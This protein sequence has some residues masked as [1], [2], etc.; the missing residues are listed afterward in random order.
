MTVRP[1]ADANTG[2]RQL[3]SGVQDLGCETIPTIRP[4]GKVKVSSCS[5]RCGCYRNPLFVACANIIK[6]GFS[7]W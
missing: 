5:L 6:T 4:K 3:V 2:A 7:I 1:A